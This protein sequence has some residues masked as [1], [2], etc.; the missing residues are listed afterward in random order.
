VCPWGPRITTRKITLVHPK[1]VYGQVT[2]TYAQSGSQCPANPLCALSVNLCRLYRAT[3][4]LNLSVCSR[5]A[6]SVGNRSMLDA[7]KK[8]TTPSV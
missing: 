8:P 2:R 4:A 6:T 5:M 3:A 1:H 7:P